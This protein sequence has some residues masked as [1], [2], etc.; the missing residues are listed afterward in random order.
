VTA[1]RPLA[2]LYILSAPCR[3][4]LSAAPCG[5]LRTS[6][7][8]RLKNSWLNLAEERFTAP[9]FNSPVA[10]TRAEKSRLSWLSDLVSSPLLTEPV[11]DVMAC[12]VMA[13]NGFGGNEDCSAPGVTKKG[14]HQKCGR[15]HYRPPADTVRWTK[16]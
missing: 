4:G 12:D 1:A 13:C 14:R 2:S 15:T 3:M 10:R 16:T 5:R 6:L 9:L 11:A 8:H 7:D